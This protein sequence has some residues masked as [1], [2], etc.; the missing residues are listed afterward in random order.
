MRCAYMGPPRTCYMD[1]LHR[2]FQLTAKRALASEASGFDLVKSSRSPLPGP[3]P[4]S[5]AGSHPSG[6]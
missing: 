4:A 2:A 6:S 3:D 5:T 1:Y